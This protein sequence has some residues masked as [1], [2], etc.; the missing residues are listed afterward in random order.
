VVLTDH[1]H[2]SRRDENSRI[3]RALPDKNSRIDRGKERILRLMERHGLKTLQKRRFRPRT[4][5][6]VSRAFHAGQ[7]PSVWQVCL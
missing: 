4:T 3:R 5:Q 1:G 6:T 2:Q 7:S